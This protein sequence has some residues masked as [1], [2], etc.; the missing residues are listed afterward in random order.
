MYTLFSYIVCYFAFLVLNILGINEREMENYRFLTA[1][2][3]AA[4]HF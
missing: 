1:S 3:R 2:V 4:D